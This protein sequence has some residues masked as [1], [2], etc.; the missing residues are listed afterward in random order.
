M[1]SD[2]VKPKKVMT[3]AMLANLALARVAAKKKREQIGE[4]TR[5]KKEVIEKK[6]VDE[7]SSLRKVLNTT[8]ND[9]ADDDEPTLPPPPIKKQKAPKAPI[10][11]FEDSES[12]EEQVF[13][14][15]RKS[16]F[17]PVPPP[18]QVVPPII[19]PPK[20]PVSIYQGMHPNML[21]GRRRY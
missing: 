14:V 13:Y 9:D 7:I 5:L 2:I 18:V 20:V 10:L 1:N 6:Q 12:D 4:L 8:P 21:S 17:A 11:I 19:E 16:R 15:K 3:E